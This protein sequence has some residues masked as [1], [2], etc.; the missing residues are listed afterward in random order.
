MDLKVLPMMMCG[1]HMV[2]MWLVLIQQLY[3]NH[4]SQ[5]RVTRKLANQKWQQNP[6]KCNML[7]YMYEQNII[8]WVWD[9]LRV[10]GL[11][12]KTAKSV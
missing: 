5:S 10:W 9:F 7:Y 12:H 3:K 4:R 2:V 8:L 6:F 11:W 1:S